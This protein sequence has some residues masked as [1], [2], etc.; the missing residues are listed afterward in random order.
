MSVG[1][2]VKNK[3]Q[4]FKGWITEVLGRATRNRKL[5]RHG[6]VERVSG[7]LRQAGEKARHAFRR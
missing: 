6:K 2:T 5:E 7:N 3:T 4:E 1:Q